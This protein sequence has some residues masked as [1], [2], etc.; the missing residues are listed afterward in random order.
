LVH[1]LDVAQT[2]LLL[3]HTDGLNGEIFNLAD[4]APISLYELAAYSGFAWDS[5]GATEG[6]LV[7]PFDGIMDI[8]KLK[9]KTCFR[10]L[11][12]S[13]YAARDLDIL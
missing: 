10:P 3:L 4:D 7:N 9:H 2:L 12:A 13:Y 1:H 8:S 6:V 11:V 5:F